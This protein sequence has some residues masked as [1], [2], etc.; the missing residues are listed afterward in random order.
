MGYAHGYL[1]ADQIIEM[2]KVWGI[3]SKRW[4]KAKEQE[5]PKLQFQQKYIE[6][7]KGMLAGM[8]DAYGPLVLNG[9]EFTLSD[10][11][12]GNTF[13]GACRAFTVFGPATQ[14]Q[15]TITLRGLGWRFNK[16]P[17]CT[18]AKY[19]LIFAYAPEG[20]NRF[21]NIA[22]PGYLGCV[23][24]VNE[25]GQAIFTNN[26]QSE[27]RANPPNTQSTLIMRQIMEE[28]KEGDI[29]NYAAAFFKNNHR[30]REGALI[31]VAS[32]NRNNPAGVIELD[33]DG[34]V[35]RLPEDHNDNDRLIVFNAYEKY[36]GRKKS[37]GEDR[38][39]VEEDIDG[40][41]R[42]GD[43][44][45]DMDELRDIHKHLTD[46]AIEKKGEGEPAQQH[47]FVVDLD[48]LDFYLSV[49]DPVNMLRATHRPKHSFKWSDV[50]E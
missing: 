34:Q 12:L 3:G 46:L 45:V 13:G 26:V 2:A 37:K 4:E 11:K 31:T 14:D 10:I 42:T 18:M 16:E 47:Q 48:T 28:Y 33:G 20:E 23:T 38:N 9:A 36:R 35:L 25:N 30:A 8:K 41:K 39:L 50:F 17:G 24:A 49:A 7:M 27:A 44:K 32:K 43:K 40:Y 29:V 22:F 21:I 6:E 15:R 1:L 19:T 5:L